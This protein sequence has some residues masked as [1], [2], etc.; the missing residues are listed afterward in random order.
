MFPAAISMQFIPLLSG[1]QTVL[2]LEVET[3]AI[4]LYV[5]YFVEDE[6]CAPVVP[7]IFRAFFIFN[8]LFINICPLLIPPIC[9]FQCNHR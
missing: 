4:S 6:H 9:I 5:V 8:G 2:F 3:P 1:N 7:G